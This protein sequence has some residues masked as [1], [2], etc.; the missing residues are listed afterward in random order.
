VSIHI[1]YCNC[2]LTPSHLHLS[3]THTLSRYRIPCRLDQTTHTTPAKPLTPRHT[4]LPAKDSYN[5]PLIG[6]HRP[7]AGL[8]HVVTSLR[9][10]GTQTRLQNRSKCIGR[11]SRGLLLCTFICPEAK[12][13]FV[14]MS[15]PSGPIESTHC[16]YETVE[17]LNADL[18]PSLK[19]LVQYP[20]FRHYKVDLFRECPFWYE[21][22]FCMNRDCGVE[23]ADE[24]SLFLAFGRKSVLMAAQSEIPEKW[25]TR[26]LSEVRVSS[27]QDQVSSCYFREQD[28][29]YIEGD[30][31]QGKLTP[32][33]LKEHS[34]CFRWAVRRPLA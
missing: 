25:R 11:Q 7:R 29:C 18:F 2:S 23:T 13:P 4:S 5:A 9:Q 10:E 14:L 30:A 17:S 6:H 15:Q 21:N 12:S 24:V 19:A 31:N 28:F 16:L 20:F 27:P 34:S 3:P 22:G 8:E 32:P 1:I 33:C 26:A